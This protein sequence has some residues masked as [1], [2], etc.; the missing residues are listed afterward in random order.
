M[1]STYEHKPSFAYVL[2]AVAMWASNPGSN[3][4]PSFDSSHFRDEFFVHTYTYLVWICIGRCKTF[5]FAYLCN[6][7]RIKDS[8]NGSVGSLFPF[9]RN[10]ER[11]DGLL[12][13]T[14][15][16]IQ[17]CEL[18]ELLDVWNIKLER[19]GTIIIYSDLVN[20]FYTTIPTASSWNF[21]GLNF[22]HGAWVRIT[23]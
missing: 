10:P 13:N 8:T 16:V 15:T 6:G 1:L 22:W 18:I 17:E 23:K 14:L 2:C 19:R 21:V 12:L 7:L 9:T 4:L 11:L 3:K 5:S 20:S